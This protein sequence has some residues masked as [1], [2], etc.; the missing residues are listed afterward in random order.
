MAFSL[1][2]VTLKR[3]SEEWVIINGEIRNETKRDYKVS[4]F[5]MF[6]YDSMQVVAI[7]LIKVYDF[8]A[9]ST[10]TFEILIEGMNYKLIPSVVRYE[11]VLESGY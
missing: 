6:L 9:R 8:R 5:R 2:N 7:G 10:R 4:I 3:G 11:V 1:F